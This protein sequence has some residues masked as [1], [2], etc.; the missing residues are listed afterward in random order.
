M[1]VI[2]NQ[3]LRPVVIITTLHALAHNSALQAC[4]SGHSITAHP[5]CSLIQAVKKFTAT[6]PNRTSPIHYLN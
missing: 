5:D 6:I 4:V 1:G 2:V 3:G